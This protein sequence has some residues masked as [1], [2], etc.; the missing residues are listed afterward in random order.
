[1]LNGNG[2]S[3]LKQLELTAAVRGGQESIIY[4]SY[5]RSHATGN[6]N[7][8]NSYLSNYPRQLLCSTVTAVFRAMYP[9]AFWL[10]E[11]FDF[12]C[13]FA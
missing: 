10:G 8:F 9:V 4:L 12:P 6:L 7:E 1:M 11:P 2:S 13:N 5:V 3:Q